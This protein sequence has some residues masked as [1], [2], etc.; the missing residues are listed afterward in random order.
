MERRREEEKEGREVGLDVGGVNVLS[1]IGWEE[2][3]RTRTWSRRGGGGPGGVVVEEKRG[4]RRT[5][6]H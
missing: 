5:K 3:R 2:R 1:S 6:N 4:G